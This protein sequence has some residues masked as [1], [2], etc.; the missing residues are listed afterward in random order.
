MDVYSCNSSELTFDMYCCVGTVFDSQPSM[1]IAHPSY[2]LT[3]TKSCF[4]KCNNT[5]HWKLLK[6]ALLSI[7]THENTTVGYRLSDC[8]HIKKLCSEYSRPPYV[9]YMIFWVIVLVVAFFGNLMVIL[10]IVYTRKLRKLNNSMFILSLAFS[11]LLVAMFIVPLKL[12]TAYHNLHFCETIFLCRAYITIDNM[13]FV[14]SITNLLVL[15]IDRFVALEHTFAYMTIITR[16]RGKF[17]V[18]VV[19]CYAITWGIPANFNW[20]DQI[21]APIVI[22]ETLECVSLNKYYITSI[23]CGIFYLPGVIMCFLYSRIYSIARRH[24]RVIA[25]VHKSLRSNRDSNPHPRIISRLTSKTST[26]THVTVNEQV[27]S[28]LETDDASCIQ[29]TIR[30]QFEEIE[31]GVKNRASNINEMDENDYPK[32]F[33]PETSRRGLNKEKVLMYQVTKTIATVYGCFLICWFPVSILAIGLSWSQTSFLSTHPWPHILIAEILPVLN[34]TMNPFIYS[35]TSKQY[36]KAFYK[37]VTD[38]RNTFA[39]YCHHA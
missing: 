34:S 32:E 11:D 5:V 3:A 31:M 6:H 17:I 37:L 8:N 29:V 1:T 19:W 28:N 16:K 13:L 2:L 18:A 38:I 24:V 39:S 26:I 14:A 22:T 23:F 7:L 10:S 35:L 15:T 30:E 36:R 25:A 27:Y 21:T 9:L 20:S 4:L 12:K 33:I